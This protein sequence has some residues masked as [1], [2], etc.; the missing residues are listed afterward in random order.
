MIDTWV[1][2]NLPEDQQKPSFSE[3]D[4]EAWLNLEPR[5]QEPVVSGCKSSLTAEERYFVAPRVVLFTEYNALPRMEVRFS[6]HNVFIRDNGICQYCNIPLVRGAK[7]TIRSGFEEF[8]V[9]H[10]NPR[11]RGGKS[12]WVNIVAACKPCNARKGDR[13]PEEA[14]MKL[15]STPKKPI[16]DNNLIGKVPRRPPDWIHFLKDSKV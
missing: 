1:D 3:L 8:S 12:T 6:N 2:P 9:D 5:E 16:W 13:T 10:I 14:S 4:L 11:A 15:L 7:A